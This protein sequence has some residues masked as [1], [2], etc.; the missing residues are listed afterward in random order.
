MIDVDVLKRDA[1]F[2]APGAVNELDNEPADVNSDGVQVHLRAAPAAPQ[3]DWLV[4]PEPPSGVR[5]RGRALAMPGAPW[6][7]AAA[8]T[9]ATGW[10]VVCAIRIAGVLAAGVPFRLAVVVNDMSSGRE[11]RRGQLVLGAPGR[12]V[13]LRGD[14][15]AADDSFSFVIADE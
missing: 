5:V 13:Y 4:V 11:R 3:F 14:R 2:A 7:H 8:T 1:H 6:L 9:T 10:R 15:H 12:F